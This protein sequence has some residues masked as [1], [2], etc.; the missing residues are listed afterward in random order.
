[1]F[2][3]FLFILFEI[4]GCSSIPDEPPNI[5]VEIKNQTINA[6]RGGYKWET[7]GLFSNRGVIADAADPISIGEDLIA[8]SVGPNSTATVKFSDASNPT[9]TANLWEGQNQ[10]KTLPVKDS[11][12]ALPS[13]KGKHVIEIFAKWKNGRASYIF[14]IEVK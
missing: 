2:V 1:M 6:S 7:K 5:S 9:I 11:E 12:I 14:V 10:T 3:A 8:Q 13:D 4:S